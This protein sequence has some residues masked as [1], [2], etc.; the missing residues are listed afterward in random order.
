MD[1]VELISKEFSLQTT[2][3]KYSIMG[4][5]ISR[6]DAEFQNLLLSST[7]SILIFEKATA[8]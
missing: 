6:E 8:G 2:Q 1:K 5:M 4:R 3:A 7:L